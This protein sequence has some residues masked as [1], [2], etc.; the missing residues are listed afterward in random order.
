M[1]L[2]GKEVKVG[3]RVRTAYTLGTIIRIEE[4]RYTIYPFRIKKNKSG[5]EYT[6]TPDGLYCN[7]TLDVSYDVVEV[8]DD[9]PSTTGDVLFD[10]VH[11]KATEL[12]LKNYRLTLENEL[13]AQ[14][15]QELR[16]GNAFLNKRIDR[17]EA[18]LTAFAASRDV[19]KE[20]AE[21]YER[22]L[23][24]HPASSSPKGGS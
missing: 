20:L 10:A 17:L 13:L 8:L 18:E 9:E 16:E 23:T 1:K 11:S 3:A 12:E 5:E 15:V 21:K 2:L 19:W 24:G 7:D 22:V 4:H 6:V 14:E